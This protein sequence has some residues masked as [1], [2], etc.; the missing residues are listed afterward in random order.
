MKS[1]EFNKIGYASLPTLTHED[2]KKAIKLISKYLD[3]EDN[4]FY[5]MVNHD[6]H[7]FTVFEWRDRPKAEVAGEVVDI[8]KS[9]GYIKSIEL[10]S[11]ESMIE[12]WILNPVANECYMYGFFAYDQGVIT[13]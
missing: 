1:Y 7:Y 9:L 13:L 11:N 8:A 3:K 12:I 10:S 5:M 4:T 2:E 6:T